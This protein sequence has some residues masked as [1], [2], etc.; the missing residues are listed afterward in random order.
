MRLEKLKNEAGSIDII[1]AVLIPFFMAS[2]MV[3]TGIGIVSLAGYSLSDPAFSAGGET[4]TWAFLGAVTALVLAYM[5][6]SPNL[7]DLEQ[8]E[9]IAVAG[10]L[11][12][13]VGAE[14]VPAFDSLL[15]SHPAVALV[16]TL[17][18]GIGFYVVA[19]Y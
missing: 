12:I 9:T 17:I 6:N 1:D 5:S 2:S 10:T 8:E 3:V 14:F 7:S 19:Y 18:T 13:I 16:A 4:L 15:G 11:L